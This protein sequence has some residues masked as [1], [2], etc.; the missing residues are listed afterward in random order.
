MGISQVS[1]SDVAQ[2]NSDL[3]RRLLSRQSILASC[4]DSVGSFAAAGPAVSEL[5]L[6]LTSYYLPQRYPS[7]FSINWSGSTLINTSLG[8]HYPLSP[9]PSP[10]Q[11]LRRLGSIID[12]DFMFLLPAPDGDGYNLQAYVACFASGFQVG[13]ILGK[14]LREL[15]HEVPG[16]RNRL[17]PSMER[18]FGALQVGKIARRYNWTVT[19]H[20]RLRNDVGE[21]QLYTEN[22]DADDRAADELSIHCVKAHLRTELQHIW[23]LPQTKAI[24]FSYKTHVYPL[25]ELKAQG[26]GDA[27]A[28]AIE[29]LSKGNAPEIVRYKRATIWG[30][31]VCKYLRS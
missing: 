17:Q 2:I 6:F 18:W 8:L 24:V 22:Q 14:R 25:S 16:Y 20:G 4:P 27:L 12:E 21:N 11:T 5:Y 7:L 26:E 19:L 10:E 13:D 9:D 1:I 29:G 3:S 31:P 23:R 28:T 15:H 30:K